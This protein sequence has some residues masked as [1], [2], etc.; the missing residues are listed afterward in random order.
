[1][2]SQAILNKYA[3]VMIKFALWS[4]KGANPKDVILLQIPESAKAFLEPL[5]NAVLKIGAYPLVD[6]L[7]EGINK[8]Y[9]ELASDD[10]L[11]FIPEKY[12]LSKVDAITHRI[13][14]LADA[15]PKELEGIDSKKIMKRQSAMKPYREALNKKEDAGLYTWSLCLF[16]TEAMAKEAGLSLE[17]YWEQI[18]KACYLDA[19]DPV[20][21]WIEVQNQLEETKSKL[22]ALEI[23]WAHVQGNDVDLKIKLGKDRQWLGGSGRNIPSFELFISPDWRGTEGWIKFNQPLYHYGSLIKGIEL[24]FKDGLVVSCKATDNEQLL[25]DMIAAKDADKIGEFSLTDKRFSRIEKFMANT[26]FDENI[27]GE[28]GNTHIAVGNAYHD[29]YRGDVSSVTDAQWKEMGFNESIVHTDIIST[30]NR[31]VTATLS[32]GTQKVIYENG[33]FTV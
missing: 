20:A 25:K 16:G 32:D 19:V 29:S 4:G 27:G 5:R 2:P 7:P 9:Y 24:E 8:S 3:E 1:M 31:R 11:S 15:D 17:E 33:M 21:K 23:E 18:I 26:L 28:F 13:Y 10:Q 12:L 14:V 30:T 6:Y 22:N